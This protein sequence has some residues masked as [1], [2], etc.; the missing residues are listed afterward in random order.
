MLW[1]DSVAPNAPRLLGISRNPQGPGLQLKWQTPL[2]AADKEAVFGYV[3]YRFYYGEPVNLSDPS[4]ILH[5]QY[6]PATS[7][8]DPT[9]ERGKVYVYVI[10]ALDR[11]KNE[12]LPASVTFNYQ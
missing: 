11:L 7:A 2:L 9:A 10:T 4:H 3:I 12:S 5:I 1:L 8:N 6:D